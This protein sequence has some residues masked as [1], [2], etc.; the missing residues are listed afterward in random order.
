[1]FGRK[2]IHANFNPGNRTN[3]AF[4]ICVNVTLLLLFLQRSR[5]D[6]K[7]I[8]KIICSSSKSSK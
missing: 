8:Q 5:S 7:A 3:Y 1:M 4:L 6:I 2:R